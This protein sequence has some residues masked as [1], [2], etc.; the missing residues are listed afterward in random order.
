MP[1]VLDVSIAAAW[2]F[3]DEDHPNAAHALASLAADHALVPP[4]WWYEIR[5]VM[6]V[7]ERR[8]RLTEAKTAF[9]L[10]RLATLP[11]AVEPLGDSSELLRLARAHRLTAYDA[12]YLE[13]A[14][15]TGSPLATLDADLLCAARNEGVPL[16]EAKPQ[17]PGKNPSR[18]RRP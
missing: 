6:V 2:A 18:T 10:A 17:P 15:M 8:G 5:N 7:N 14:K 1:F 11:I 9:F 4:L 12:A 3:F 13:L 16:L